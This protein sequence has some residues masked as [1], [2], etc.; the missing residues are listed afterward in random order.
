MSDDSLAH[1]YRSIVP[2]NFDN[3][4]PVH[5]SLKDQIFAV[6][7]V[8]SR[9]GDTDQGLRF[10]LPVT[11]SS[12]TGIFVELT[13]GSLSSM[14]SE[15][16]TMSVW[17]NLQSEHVTVRQMFTPGR[18]RW[19]QMENT[20]AECAVRVSTR[21]C[22]IEDLVGRNILGYYVCEIQF[23]CHTGFVSQHAI[24]TRRPM[25][26]NICGFVHCTLRSGCRNGDIP[27]RVGN[28]QICHDR[29]GIAFKGV[30]DCKDMLKNIQGFVKNV[31]DC[32]I[33]VR[34]LLHVVCL[35]NEYF[36]AFASVCHQHPVL[37]PS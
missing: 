12:G 4:I 2:P 15:S 25:F 10:K 36:F 29:S 23:L 35:I 7:S 1:C 31:Q 11:S 34:V 24:R 14:M 6:L 3:G 20:E 33:V 19:L 22:C 5:R 18:E 16:P 17:R 21:N 28:L 27:H 26:E 13:H 32:R 8:S 30:R 37:T 9:A